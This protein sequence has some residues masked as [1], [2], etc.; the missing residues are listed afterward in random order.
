MFL[1]RRAKLFPSLGILCDSILASSYRDGVETRFRSSF[2]LRL[3]RQRQP[4]LCR[5]E[6]LLADSKKPSRFL[7]YQYQ[8]RKN[9]ELKFE[10]ERPRSRPLEYF[11]APTFSCPPMAMPKIDNMA[12]VK[13][14]SLPYPMLVVCPRCGTGETLVLPQAVT[15][16]YDQSPPAS[17]NSRLG[18][19]TLSFRSTLSK[20]LGFEYGHLLASANFSQSTLELARSTVGILATWWLAGLKSRILGKI[21]F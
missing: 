7:G 11:W 2:L 20:S 18:S 15:F 16:Q 6:H 14:I 8:N 9:C 13:W 12:I 1:S 10:A 5:P 19:R 21:S 17:L 3:P 4:R